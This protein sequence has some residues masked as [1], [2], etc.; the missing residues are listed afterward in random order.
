M[1]FFIADILAPDNSSLPSYL[2]VASHNSV[3]SIIVQQGGSGMQGAGAI[4]LAPNT[5]VLTA[6]GDLLP[7]F[8]PVDLQ[9]VG[10]R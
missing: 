8:E 10:G 4:R 9:G 3:V 2:W 5:V 7:I 6:L 1:I